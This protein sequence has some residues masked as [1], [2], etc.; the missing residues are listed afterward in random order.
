MGQSISG[1]VSHTQKSRVNCARDTRFVI[2]CCYV[3]TP[4]DRQQSFLCCAVVVVVV[5]AVST[6]VVDWTREYSVQC[7]R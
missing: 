5:V 3:T 4:L 2:T 7:R 6:A 1:H